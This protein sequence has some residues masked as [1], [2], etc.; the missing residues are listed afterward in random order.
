MTIN[1]LAIVAAAVAA[2]LAGAVWYGVLAKPRIAALGWTD[3]D[4]TDASGKRV[5]PVGPM[6]ISFIAELIMAYLM[7]GLLY[8][9]GGPNPVRGAIAGALIWLGFVVTTNAVNNAYQRRKLMLT[10]IDSG[11]WLVVLVLQ[12]VVLGLFR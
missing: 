6:I 12:G 8:H 1:Y 7:S 10:I 3:A 5:M 2:W 9:L 11:H 4:V